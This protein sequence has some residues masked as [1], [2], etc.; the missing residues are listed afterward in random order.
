MTPHEYLKQQ[1]KNVE[2][3]LTETLRY[4]YGPKPTWDYYQECCDRLDRIKLAIA[5]TDK[6]DLSGIEARLDELSYL[7]IWISLIERSRLGEFSWPFAE[8]LRKMAEVLLAETGLSGAKIPPIVHIVSDGEGYLIH[9]ETTSPSGKHKFAFIAFPRPLKHHVLLHSLFGHELGHTALHTV[10]AGT[11][12]QNDVMRALQ[13]SGPL[14]SIGAMTSWLHDSAAPTAIKRELNQYQLMTGSAYAMTEYY[15]LQWLDELI[16]D[17]FGLLLFGPGFAAAHQVFLRPMQPN[18]YEFGPSDPTHPP[19]AIRHRMLV[20]TM[21]LIGWQTPVATL[22]PIQEAEKEL[23]DYVLLDNFDPWS[24][25]LSDGQL[26]QA[27]AGVQKVFAAY[28]ALG[29]SL[30]AEQTL[31]KLV[32]QLTMRLPPIIAGL[33]NR[34]VPELKETDITHTLYAGWVYAIGNRHLTREPLSFLETNMLCDHALLQQRA[35]NIALKKKM[36]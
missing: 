13:S 17:L 28:G 11:I 8:A 7:S 31:S 15:R 35:I 4:D 14:A 29:Y 34:G 24:T 23:L 30:P 27:V 33:S 2:Q 1:A 32:E 26:L 3:A 36:K 21:Q 12:L 19:Y 25:I 18:P 10:G 5:G 22:S 9:Y 6:A 20:R 16:C